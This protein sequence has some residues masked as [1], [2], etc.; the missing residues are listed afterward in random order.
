MGSN[1]E[2]VRTLLCFESVTNIKVLPIS[3]L[4]F[5]VMSFN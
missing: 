2:M 3:S 1:E 5:K 4:S